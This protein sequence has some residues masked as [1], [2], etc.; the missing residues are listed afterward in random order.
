[1]SEIIATDPDFPET[2]LGWKNPLSFVIK[3]PK[4]HLNYN[5]NRG[6]FSFNLK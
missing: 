3:L 6:R 4:E 5:F 2:L 1:M